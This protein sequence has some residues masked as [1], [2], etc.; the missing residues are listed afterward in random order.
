M[1]LDFNSTKRFRDFVLS[2]TL[3]VP[4][5]PQ[6]FTE[7]DYR[8]KN[9][10]DSANVD[11]GAVDTNRTA[12]LLQ[13]QNAN[14]Y[15]PLRY[16]VIEEFNVIPRRANLSLYY[17]GT[18]YFVA[19]NHTLVGIMSN[20]NYD[21]E[22]ELF[23]FAA[24]YIQD[25]NQKGPVYSRIEQNLYR[26]TVGRVRLIDALNGNLATATNIV[27]G[28]EPLVESNYQITV[29]KSPTGKAIDFL[30]TV[31]GVE[32]PW[33]EIPGDYLSNPRNPINVRPVPNSQFGKIFQDT[34]GA[35]GS[36]LGI[37]RRPKKDRKPSDLFIEYMGSGQKQTLFD[38]L[39]YS[40]YAPN[41][42]T[43]ARS[44]NT[45]RLFNFT[46]QFA[47]SAKN[48]LGVE[49]PNS[50]AYIGDD[51]G[52]DLKYAMNDFNDRPVRGSYYMGLLF[53][54]VQTDLFE[55]QKNI[56][57]GGQLSGKLT[58]I[59]INSRNKLGEHNKEYSSQR[60][61]F[62]D[63]LST[64]REF[65]D[66]SLLGY[67]QDI[68]DSMPT[69]GGE[70][71]SHVANVID[72]TSRIFRDGTKYMS[73]GSAI[74]YVDKFG[75]ESGVEY[76]RVW[77]K[78][79][80]YMSN[81]DTM[82]KGGNIRK[83]E[84]TIVKDPWNLNIAPMSNGKK[85]FEGSSNIFK[86]GPVDKDGNSF[87][88][89]KY[90]FSIENLAWKSSF[91]PG[92]TVIDLP[93]C[94]RG[95]N[96]GRVMWFPPYD[97]KISENNNAT[98]ESNKFL[99][100]PEP[101]Y[102]YSST[103]RTGQLSFKIV[104]D[105]PS[106]LN[107]LT[108]EVFANLSDE[109]ADNYIDAFFAG[110]KD[111]D[112]YDLIRRYSTLDKTD[113]QY[114]LDYLN[115]AGKPQEIQKYKV[116]V[117]QVENK[118]PNT[119]T[120]ENNNPSNQSSTNP[121]NVTGITLNF[122]ND[123]PKS[124]P[125]PYTSKQDTYTNNYNSYIGK[126]Q[127]YVNKLGSLIQ[128]L[129]S[130]SLNDKNAAADRNILFG[131]NSIDSNYVEIQKS[132]LE[133]YFTQLTNN[134]TTYTNSTDKLKTDITEKKAKNITVNILSSASSIASDNYN[135]L[136]SMRRSYSMLIDFLKRISKDGQ[137][138][139]SEIK[140]P[141]ASELGGDFKYSNSF[142]YNLKDLGW[143]EYDSTIKIKIDSIGEND[144]TTSTQTIDPS[145]WR[146]DF[147]STDLRNLNV[148]SPIAFYCRKSEIDFKYELSSTP[149][150]PPNP[151]PPKPLPNTISKTRLEQDGTVTLTR[152][153][154]KPPIDV[155][156]RIIM[157]T[158]SECYYFKKLEED[159]PLVFNSLREKLRY[160]HP[161]FHSTTPEGLNSRLTFLHQ[162]IRP[163]D[164]I[165]IKGISDES[166]LNA[167]NTSF[168]PPPICV[169]RIGDF[170]HSRIIVRDVNITY[171][172]SPWDMNP[173]GIGMQPMIASV[174]MSI[175]FIGGQGLEEPVARLQNALS[176]NFYANTEIYDE[177]SIA[178]N[179][180]IAGKDA[181]QFTKEFLEDLQKR[182]N[183]TPE[184]I[185]NKV[186]NTIE[187]GTY[188]GELSANTLN[189]DK[190]VD[191][192]FTETNTY[193]LE[194]INNYNIIVQKY[195]KKL[196]SMA[197]SP[198]YRTINEYE[199][200]KGNNTTTNIN[201]FG[202][203]QKGYEL[204]YLTRLFINKL[205][206][207]IESTDL[208][209]IFGFDKELPIGSIDR[210]NKLLRPKV[211]E[212]ATNTLTEL[213]SKSA[214]KCLEE[215]RNKLITALDQ[216]NFIVKY[217]KDIK[218]DKDKNNK[219]KNLEIQLSGFTRDML[220]NQYSSCIDYLTNNYSKLYSDL[221]NSI[222][223]LNP[224]ITTLGMSEILSVIL[225]NDKFN[226]ISVFSVDKTLFNDK[227]TKKLT[228]RLDSFI[229]IPKSKDFKLNNFKLRSNKNKLTYDILSETE[230]TDQALIEDGKK[231]KS[232]VVIVKD[233]LNYYKIKKQ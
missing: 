163:G 170:Y 63:S 201:I 146:K 93:F 64:S 186:E 60:S 192:I 154:K 145:C 94:E 158:L 230:S 189:Y 177:R 153:V 47:Q 85:G 161:G 39:A 164:T 227:T 72:Q 111:L 135:F 21:N 13:S 216:V 16:N 12:D 59:S 233:K 118:A 4:N 55:N 129:N 79:R 27:T 106:I 222:D 117:D 185:E 50:N 196:A 54:A 76:C 181:N 182:D 5:G 65:R 80:P 36:L 74:K 176:S 151:E 41:Y 197:L 128:T 127:D 173:E 139:P 183:R 15:K 147:V 26:A 203:Y 23:K 209:A 20:R 174:T 193:H 107:L 179:K 70:A 67:T 86:G 2:K 133:K 171:D 190:I 223:F 103:E 109:E 165:P 218:I 140:W 120:T 52:N 199:I 205:N 225:Q 18:P 142:E 134:F 91:K 17:S 40:K 150:P 125:N 119:L 61:K 69:N 178:T 1:P 143:T 24:S 217:E 45:S 10:N 213:S 62:E 210:A 96:G 212:I 11:P 207:E 206:T 46:D 48:L 31:A 124:N 87:Y 204:E 22:S 167:R 200:T 122:D 43:T 42:T 90:M 215:Q 35:L 78:D 156:K 180:I 121:V 136:L 202:L 25:R 108:R 195:G 88:A 73:R 162:C 33:V 49:A 81:S 82:K 95:P 115:D 130:K 51:R 232:S 3:Q 32:F 56:T 157:K 92:F 169:L 152:R 8:Y 149:T 159:S 102:T 132:E 68:L 208:C 188:I 99:G 38:L 58:W 37:E 172:D 44:Q 226:I 114:I 19:E 30:Q 66:D 155:M 137:T 28:K 229:N 224:T 105:H 214:I 220:Y 141:K 104:V 53:D 57:D 100:R 123:Y 77:T 83:F 211:K 191:N 126:K 29:A 89:K 34:T 71:R 219:D 184:P 75:Q 138:L 166:D 7:N 97:L 116:V 9:L 148:V 113:I 6:T 160:F 84:A 110:C 231:I 198:T 175:S 187:S 144:K 98:W 131:S 168:G 221:D 101:I 112:F 194:F 14:V 228:N